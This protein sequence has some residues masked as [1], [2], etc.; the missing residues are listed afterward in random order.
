MVAVKIDVYAKTIIVSWQ[1]VENADNY[2][3]KISGDEILHGTRET[4][5]ELLP[6]SQ[7]LEGNHSIMVQAVNTYDPEQFIASEWCKVDFSVESTKLRVP[8]SLNCDVDKENC[9][10]NV[11]WT[12]V[13]N[14]FSYL[15][16]IDDGEEIAAAGT[17][18][19]FSLF[20]YTPGE[21]CM[22]VRALAEEMS[23][24]HLASDWSEAYFTITDEPLPGMLGNKP[25]DH[26]RL[27]DF[28]LNDGS[29]VRADSKLSEGQANACIGIVFYSGRHETDQSDYTQPLTAGG[30]VLGNTVHGYVMSLTYVPTQAGSNSNKNVVEFSHCN[31]VRADG[32][33]DGDK[34]SKHLY[35]CRGTCRSRDDFNGY[36]NCMA[37]LNYAATVNCCIFPALHVAINYGKRGYRVE[38][39]TEN[40]YDFWNLVDAG[41]VYDW[42]LSLAAPQNS[43]GWFLPSYGQ[44]YYFYPKDSYSPLVPADRTFVR[45]QIEKVKNATTREELKEHIDPQYYSFAIHSYYSSS[46][47]IRNDGYGDCYV[48][49][50]YGD[51]YYGYGCLNYVRPVLAF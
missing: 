44:L 39:I 38:Y 19:S 30:P 27:G 51:G 20:D 48:V 1:A 21:H 47:F 2:H 35:T 14:A 46:E 9:S 8:E 42:Q 50:I 10:V 16:K 7:F 34:R 32:S 11:S 6:F 28:Y 12:P 24:D 3:Y 31:A 45:G 17:E 5:L 18:V 23:P 41:D 43:S 33:P 22:S 37:I 49:N 4:S 25:L 13:E 36:Y 26:A 29:L 15:Y 40:G